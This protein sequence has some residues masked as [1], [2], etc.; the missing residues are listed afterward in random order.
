MTRKQAQDYIVNNRHKTI[1][2]EGIINDYKLIDLIR[3]QCV[4]MHKDPN[5]SANFKA[6]AIG[7]HQEKINRIREDIKAKSALLT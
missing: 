2:A 1:I 6:M 3:E 4:E 7:L 5:I